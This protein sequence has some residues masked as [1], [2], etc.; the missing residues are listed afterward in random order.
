[1]SNYLSILVIAVVLML[2]LATRLRLI[3]WDLSRSPL[4]RIA[5]SVFAVILVFTVGLVNVVSLIVSCLF[6]NH[7]HL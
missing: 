4:L 3:I 5:I 7:L 2:L 1:M 6:D